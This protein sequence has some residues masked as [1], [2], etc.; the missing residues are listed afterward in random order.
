[1]DKVN[2][3]QNFGDEFT[4]CD[5][6]LEENLAT[7]TW[8]FAISDS[9]FLE[10][11]LA[12][13]EDST[14]R[15]P[16]N[17]RVLTPG[18]SPESPLG[19]HFR[20][21]D[22][23]SG[24]LFN[25][26]GQGA[27][28][29]FIETERD[30]ANASL[31]YF[32]GTHEIKFG[33][34][35]Q[36]VASTTLN[37]IGTSFRGTG[38]NPNLPG[39]FVTPRDKRVFDPTSPVETT[40]EILSAYAQDRFDITDRF[41]LYV[42][43]RMD[44]QSF[45]NDAGTEVHSSTDFAPRL[46]ATY[47]LSGEGK[48]LLKATA[49]RYYQVAGQDLFNENYA[50]KPNGQNVFTEIAWNRETQRYDGAQRRQNLP[51]GF[52]PGTFDPYY[53]DEASVGLEWQFVPAWAF[54]V[55]G[56]MWEETDAYWVTSQF[57]AT[58]VVADVRNWD[59]AFREYEGVVLELNRAFRDNWTLRTNYAWG[60]T[61]GN[62]FGNN[63]VALFQDTL[64]EGLGGLECVGNPCIPNGR[65]DTTTRNREGVGNTGREHIL[66]IV[67]LKVFPIGEH[68][69]GLGGYFGFRAGERWGLR[70]PATLRHP[71]IANQTISTT[72][73]TE[74]RGSQQLEDTMTLNLSGHWEFPIAGQFSG[75]LGAEVVNVTN[76]QELIGINFNN[77][78]PVAG[79]L[80]FQSPREY[81]F[82][83]GVTF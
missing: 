80:A 24:R 75:R 23:G 4:P 16:Y 40:S 42:G 19:N 11:K 32:L 14:F 71:S 57:S 36:D 62:H 21:Q 72:T 44:D 77:G 8:S 82:Q 53:K 45:D 15:E 17:L 25:W 9:L 48:M 74:P 33:A 56:S 58:G 38:Y 61:T 54:E 22:Q 59:D 5:C 35:Y 20:Y 81:R 73:Y 65:T 79:K 47:D 83:I 41:N 37:V 39:G 49:G 69:I 34:D 18:A 55:R 1:M 28:Q 52:N 66:N 67:G 51:P 13:Q 70:A 7:L 26:L 30:Q 60:E 64:F 6:N 50:T 46:A 29:G 78:Q 10:S 63:E 27:G 76:E 2:I 3:N 43:V 31:N 68:S 12:T